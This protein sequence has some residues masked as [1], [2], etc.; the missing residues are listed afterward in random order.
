M[1]AI[2]DSRVRNASNFD[3]DQMGRVPK[4]YHPH[5]SAEKF[6]APF[7]EHLADHFNDEM[8]YSV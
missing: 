2:N 6:L 1:A 7:N 8:K 5:L 4:S 3:P